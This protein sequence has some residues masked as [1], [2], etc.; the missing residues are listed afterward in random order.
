MVAGRLAPPRRSAREDYAM[1]VHE[2]LVMEMETER[3]KWA[4]STR[5]YG[6]INPALR[7][8]LIFTSS[9]VAVES[10][11]NGSPAEFLVAWVPILALTISVM[12]AIDSWLKPRDKW[13]GFMT[14]RD[15][16]SDLL[17]RA[18]SVLPDN[19]A[20]LDRL[21]IEFTALR[22]RHREKNVY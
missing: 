15:D 13:R 19:H 5:L 10:R 9:I 12:T 8:F 20:T 18:R 11:L 4:L 21:R 6:T 16:L 17:L 2:E 1:A 3:R 14:D 22:R 7:V